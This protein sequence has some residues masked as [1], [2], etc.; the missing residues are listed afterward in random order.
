VGILISIFSC[1]VSPAQ[2]AP[3]FFSFWTLWKTRREHRRD[4]ITNYFTV[5]RPWYWWS[6][7]HSKRGRGRTLKIMI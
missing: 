6:W 2:A 1:I 3:G 7:S 4:K 5:W